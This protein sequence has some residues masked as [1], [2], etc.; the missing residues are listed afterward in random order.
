MSGRNLP[1]YLLVQTPS[2][3]HT[4]GHELSQEIQNCLGEQ[5]KDDESRHQAD[6]VFRI[7]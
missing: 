1:S 7:E 5:I 4:L 2:F 6:L 3:K